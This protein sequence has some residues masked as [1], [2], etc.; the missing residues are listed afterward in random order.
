M[1]EA[2]TVLKDRSCVSE[3]R[4]GCC[5]SLKMRTAVCGTRHTAPRSKIRVAASLQ[6]LDKVNDHHTDCPRKIGFIQLMH[7]NLDHFLEEFEG[8]RIK[9]SD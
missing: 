5:Q 9:F 4:S 3:I 2:D 8:F 7:T 6:T 1:H